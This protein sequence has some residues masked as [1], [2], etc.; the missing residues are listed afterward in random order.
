MGRPHYRLREL[1]A[2]LRSQSAAAATG[3]ILLVDGAGAFAPLLA[4]ALPGC[5][6]TVEASPDVARSHFLAAPTDLV[7]LHHTPGAPC[8]DLLAAFKAQHPSVAVI[9]LVA[10]G[11]EALAVQAFR[12]GAIDYFSA[13]VPLDELELSVRA[14]LEIRRR[15]REAGQPLPVG[16]LQRAL[17]YLEVH[18]AGPLRLEDAA[19]EAG[20]SVSCFARYLKSQTGLTFV[21]YLNALRIAKARDLLR[22][23]PASMLQIAL[24]CGFSNQ[25]HFNRVFRKVVGTAPGVYRKGGR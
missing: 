14:V 12:H 13:P 24:A 23:T 7:L 18:F 20:M 2:Q 8:L 11:S 6:L 10:C 9:V 16:G 3:Q 5:R 15:F 19:R 22:S 25:A 21:A 4:A 17:R 1:G